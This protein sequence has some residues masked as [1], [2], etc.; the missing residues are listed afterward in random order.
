MSSSKSICS[1]SRDT[2]S[3]SLI[4]FVIASIWYF[5]KYVD[6][7]YTRIYLWMM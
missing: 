5:R 6:I 1:K 7:I 4:A 2:K 3:G